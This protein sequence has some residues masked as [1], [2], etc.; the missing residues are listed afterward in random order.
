MKKKV[1]ERNVLVIMRPPKVITVASQLIGDPLE[2]ETRK[3]ERHYEDLLDEFEKM[4]ITI[5]IKKTKVQPMEI[6]ED[7]E[8]KLNE[9]DRRLLE[10]DNPE[11]EYINPFSTNLTEQVTQTQDQQLSDYHNYTP[12]KALTIN[13]TDWRIK[14]RVTK[15]YEK[16]TWKNE[17][18][19]GYLMN[20]DLI[21]AFGSQIQCTFFKEAVDKF[22]PILQDN[23]VYLFS[24][25]NIK[26]A[27]RKYSSI[28][29]DFSIIF[30]RQAEIVKVQDDQAIQ[31]QAFNF[32]NIT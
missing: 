10:V 5:P 2:Y 15:K 6:D 14:A 8:T 32:V 4:D 25:G 1:G 12:I 13:S 22:D 16:K 28:N 3:K 20:V 18:S 9:R 31:S 26:L 11:E 24:N 23:N 17:R 7:E 19:Q 21:D 29:N 27:N 30:D